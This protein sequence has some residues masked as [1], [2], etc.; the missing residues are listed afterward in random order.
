MFQI[1]ASIE[2]GT[3]IVTAAVTVIKNVTVTPGSIDLMTV[4]VLNHHVV[5][6]EVCTP[7]KVLPRRQ[8]IK[9]MTATV[10]VAVMYV[11]LLPWMMSCPIMRTPVK[12]TLYH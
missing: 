10:T 3:K 4:T 5:L 2:D 1:R 8:H 6:V 7:S 12:R 11:N 9:I